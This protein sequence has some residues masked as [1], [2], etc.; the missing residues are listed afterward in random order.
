MLEEPYG[1]ALIGVLDLRHGRQRNIK[2]TRI[3]LQG[4][5]MHQILGC[6]R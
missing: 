3:F 2:Y 6:S 5:I 1:N 4:N